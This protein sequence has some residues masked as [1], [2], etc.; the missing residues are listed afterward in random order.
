MGCQISLVL[1]LYFLGKTVEWILTL[2][3]ARKPVNGKSLN[4]KLWENLGQEGFETFKRPNPQVVGGKPPRGSYTLTN[5]WEI[6]FHMDN[7]LN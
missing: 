2:P 5:K 6:K 3:L 7:L 4:I 1:G